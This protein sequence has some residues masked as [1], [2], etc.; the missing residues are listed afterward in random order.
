[1]PQ[2]VRSC[3]QHCERNDV[4]DDSFTGHSSIVMERSEYGPND[5]GYRNRVILN[6]KKAETVTLTAMS[7]SENVVN[8]APDKLSKRL[9]SFS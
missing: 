5:I 2:W 6:Q 4:S 8:D 3:S 9:C 1:M 7:K